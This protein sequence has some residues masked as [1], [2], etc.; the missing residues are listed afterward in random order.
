MHPRDKHNLQLILSL[1]LQWGIKDLNIKKYTQDST[2]NL[3]IRHRVYE[4]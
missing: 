2:L 1:P 4:K 3:K